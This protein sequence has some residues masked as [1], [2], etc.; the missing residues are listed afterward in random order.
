MSTVV[1][2]DDDDTQTWDAEPSISLEKNGTLNDDVVAPAGVADIGDTIT[3]TFTVINTGNVTLSNITITDAIVGVT[4][5]GGPITL[6]PGEE[7][8][9]TFT[10]T[11]TLTQSVVD[12]LT[13]TNT[14]TVSG[15]DPHRHSGDRRR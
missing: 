5:L 14:A 10:G 15:T 2:D 3:Y 6:A 8:T 12:A 7:D 13:F 9:S 11:F 4:I 1:T